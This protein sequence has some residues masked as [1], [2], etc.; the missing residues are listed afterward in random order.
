M[1]AIKTVIS[2]VFIVG[3]IAIIVYDAKTR[4]Q[5]TSDTNTIATSKSDSASH[6]SSKKN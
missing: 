1:K 4:D 6:D 3:A 2:I 5:K